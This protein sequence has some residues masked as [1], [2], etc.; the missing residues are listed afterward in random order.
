MLETRRAI[1][2]TSKRG[3]ASAAILGRLDRIP[4]WSLPWLFIGIIGVGY[5]FTFFE[6]FN[7]NVSFIQTCLQIVPRCTLATANQYLGTPVLLNLAGYVVGTLVFSPLADRYGRKGLLVIALVITGLGSLY[8]ANAG[9][10]ANFIIGRTLTGIGVG[11]D[12]SIVNTYI[13]EMAPRAARAKYAALIYILSSLGAILGIW[14]GL[15]LTTPAAP[16]PL[17][18]PFALAGP[19]FESG[20]R[21][22]YL[23]GAALAVIGLVLRSEL[24]ESARWLISKGRI[25]EA[26]HVVARMETLARR[27]GTHLPSPTEELPGLPQASKVPYREILGDPLYLKR[28]ILLLVIWL[29][30]YMTV[31]S[32]AAG[33]TTLL[34]VLGYLP[35][36][37]GLIAAI[38]TFGFLGAALTAYWFGERLERKVWLPISGA[39]TLAGGVI[40]ALSGANTTVTALGSM[41][42][43]FGFTF[44]VPMGYAWTLE[45]YPTRARATGFALT[46][47]IGHIGGGLGVSYVAAL[48]LKLGPLSTFVLIGGFLLVAAGLAQ[49]GPETRQ[50]RLDEVSP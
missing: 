13:N 42:L 49:F 39:L 46:D 29:T 12:L 33:L 1:F 21:I 6:I 31:Y 18:L 44:W 43:F 27:R 34:T 22:L 30:S 20:W 7:I 3:K 36:E 24:P 41:L 14:L 47:G 10:F 17:G 16:F 19:H 26:E 5:L 23:V 38:G 40:I 37:A 8:T 2:A 9:D 35:S 4:V 48:T 25:A 11:A 45:S 28:T 50:R 15:Y 32:V